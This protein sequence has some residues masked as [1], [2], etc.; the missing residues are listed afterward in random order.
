VEGETLWRGV[1]AYGDDAE[2]EQILTEVRRAMSTHAGS[3]FVDLDQIGRP[4]QHLG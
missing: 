2:V 4:R 3:R 1:C